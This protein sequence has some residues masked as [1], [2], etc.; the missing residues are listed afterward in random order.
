VIDMRHWACLLLCSLL[1]ACASPPP[2]QRPAHLYHDALFSPPSQRID[3][4]EVFA[5][6]EEM[7]RYLRTEIAG[8]LRSKGKHRGLLEALY[9]QGQLRIEY[10]AMTTRNASQAFAARTGNC[11]SLVIMTAALAKELDLQVTYQSALLEETWS[12][13]GNLYLRSGHVNITLGPR[14]AQPRVHGGEGALTI[15]FL[16]PEEISGMRTRPI[17]EQT[18]LAMYMNNRSAE[19][20][21][22]GQLDDAYWWAREATLQSPDF[23]SAYNTL[24]VVYL[25]HGDLPQA[26]QAL[27]HVMQREP[28]NTRAMMNLALVYRSQQRIGEAE[29]LAQRAAQIEP[30]P[31]FHYFDLGLAAMRRD[32]FRAARDL[33]AREVAR[34]GYYH[35]FHYWLGVANF[36]LGEMDQAKKHLTL[37]MENSTTRGDKDIYAAKLARLAATQ[38]H[39]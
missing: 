27:A 26:Q 32:D 19:A 4:A 7:K 16:P 3:A 38:R 21:V 36:R 2:A 39:H 13:S 17:S 14:F 10:D 31:P 24:G 9:R 18:V 30:T 1:L 8:Q 11:L 23:T 25:R 34:A 6:S 35:E 33:F 20:L 29:A 5:A 15:D 22:R 28:A 12:R 37:A